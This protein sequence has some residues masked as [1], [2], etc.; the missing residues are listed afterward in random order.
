MKPTPLMTNRWEGV[1]PVPANADVVHYRYKFDFLYNAMGPPGSD[2]VLSQEYT[3][4]II[5][6]RD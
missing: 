6:K 1:V 5:E 3:L 4:R 2:S